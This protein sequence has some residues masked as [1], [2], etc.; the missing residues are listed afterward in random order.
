[1]RRKCMGKMKWIIV[2]AMF[3]TAAVYSMQYETKLVNGYK[4][5]K[6]E[7]PYIDLSRVSPDAYEPGKLTIK[8]KEGYSFNT[9]ERFIKPSTKGYA[10]AGIASIDQVSKSV[11]AQQ[12]DRKFYSLLEIP[13]GTIHSV[14]KFKDRHEAWGFHR[15][16]EIAIPADQDVIAAVRQYAALPEVEYAEPV[17]KKALHEPTEVGPVEYDTNTPVEGPK[18]VKGSKWTPNDTYLSPNQWHYYNY[19]QTISSSVGVSGCDSRAIAAWDIEK[20]NPLFI[21]AIVDQGIDYDHPD[22]AANMWSGRG[23]NFTNNSSTINP[24][25]HGSHVGSTVAGVT[26]NGIGV[27]GL[28]GGDG[29][30]GTGSKLMSCQ[31]FDSSTGGFELAPIWAADQGASISQNSWGYTSAGVYDQA[32]LD[33]IDYF[34]ANGGQDGGLQGGI[35]I[36][37]AGN[38]GTDNQWYPGYYDGTMAVSGHDNRGKKYTSSNY[39]TW[40]EICAPAVNVYSANSSGGYMLMTGTSMACPHVSGA[41]AMIVA[42]SEGVLTATEL[43]SIL[44]TSVWDIYATETNS[45]YAGKLGTGALDASAALV[46]TQEYLGGVPTGGALSASGVS[47]S[48]INL[49]WT[50]NEF[51]DNVLVAYAIGGQAI[52]TPVNQT[53]YTIGNTIPGGGTVVYYGNSTSLNHTGLTAETA[54]D[55]KIWSRAGA[56]RQDNQGEWYQIGTYSNAKSASSQTLMTPSYPSAASMGFEN[57]GSIPA[58]WAQE[59]NWTFVT[60]ATSPT[61]PAEGSYFAHFNTTTGT[62]KKL[63]TPRFDMTGYSNLT[64]TFKY[65]TSRERISG[66][67]RNDNLKVYYKNSVTG[68]WTQ[69]AA[70]ENVNYTAWQTG[71]I[72]ISDATLS[73]DFYIAFEGIDGGSKGVSVDDI[74]INGSGGGTPPAA[75]SLVSPANASSTTDLTP[76]FDWGDVSGATT[77][78]I[79]VDNNSNFA[80]PEIN[81]SPTASTYTPASNLAT[82]TYYW[83][84]LS[85]NAYGSSSYSD[86]WTVTLGAPPAAPSLASPT[87]ASTLY[88][89]KPAFDWSDVSGATSYTI[90]VDNN[91]DFSTPEINQ[92]PTVSN[93]TPASDMAIG[94]YYWKVLSTNSFGSSA[95]SSTWSLILAPLSAPINVTTTPG[96]TDITVSWNAVDGATS[97]DVYSS[98]DPYGTFTFVT[99]VTTTSYVATPSGTKLFWYVVAKN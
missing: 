47:T 31:V 53:L 73:H 83:K 16:Y 54:Y 93:Y 86:T 42:N 70:Y 99:N 29:T 13:A 67:W 32:V 81:Q 96:A 30:A 23:W 68:S 51:N 7:R 64:L 4:V 48:Q 84:V 40:V 1:M 92:S 89:L 60:S 17:Y 26:N 49:S 75:P 12:F 46:L 57:G 37:A 72:N 62:V 27:A 97:Y 63:V 41:A 76:T 52:G 2:I 43:R 39:G 45:T 66:I 87:D 98:E 34:N 33:A 79:L 36:F 25:D 69:L 14:A 91:S 28:A 71:S 10:E 77:Y 58:G 11:Q 61:G 20:G 85:T 90:L 21:T 44:M 9:E 35:T 38:N 80:S 95:Y 94:T 50:L 74:V 5:V 24:G 59:G 78:T 19:G 56:E 88:I 15:I 22:I 18:P 82:G 55:Y 3:L 65:V 8:L 6:G